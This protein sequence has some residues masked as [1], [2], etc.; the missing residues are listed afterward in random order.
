MEPNS[1]LSC[2]QEPAT[3]PY[4]EPDESSSHYPLHERVTNQY[5]CCPT[6]LSVTRL[7]VTAFGLR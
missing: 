7:E 3:D 2:S 1:S 5:C 6:S 4:P